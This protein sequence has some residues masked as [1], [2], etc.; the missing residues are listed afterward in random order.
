[1]LQSFLALGSRIGTIVNQTERIL[2]R[3]AKRGVMRSFTLR[4]RRATKKLER[5]RPP[6]G[7]SENGRFFRCSSLMYLLGTPSSSRQKN[8]LIFGFSGLMIVPILL[9]YLQI[10]LKTYSAILA[11][12]I[13]FSNESMLLDSINSSFQ[14]TTLLIISFGV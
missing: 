13:K 7:K 12:I 9:P 5:I 2:S 3:F 14:S 6:Y 11:K 4:K 10:N 1:M 8:R